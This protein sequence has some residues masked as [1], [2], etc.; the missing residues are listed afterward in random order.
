MN[1]FL[2]ISLLFVNYYTNL[3]SSFISSSSSSSSCNNYLN[4]TNITVSSYS[5]LLQ[6]ISC[7]ISIIFISSNIYFDNEIII[8]NNKNITLIGLPSSSSSSPPSIQLTSN[9]TRIFLLTNSTLKVYNIIFNG[10]NIYSNGGI[11][12]SYQSYLLLKNCI[13]QNSIAI[14]GGSLSIQNTSLIL[15]EVQIIQ[16]QAHSLGGGIYCLTS[17]I[18]IISS[19]SSNNIAEYGGFMNLQSCNLDIQKT[20][21][22]NN[23]ATL[24]GG[25]LYITGNSDI[26]IL[27][28]SFKNCRVNLSPSGLSEDSEGGCIFSSNGVSI[29]II[30]TEFSNNFAA[31]GSVFRMTSTKLTVSDSLIHNNAG[32]SSTIEILGVS[33][34]VNVLRSKLYSNQ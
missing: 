32:L 14:N 28:S 11:I 10:G 13:L 6:S 5:E 18:Q 27:K 30:E 34:L 1:F 2:L 17:N 20:S 22:F 24:S 19:L 16:N 4:I 8:N 3:N 15:D 7:S 23:T 29:T 9:T 21:I 12:D 25:C 26:S 33:S 31:V